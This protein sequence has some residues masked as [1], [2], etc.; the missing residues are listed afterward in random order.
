MLRS[1]DG[2]EVIVPNE[3]LVTTT[4]LNHSHAS[5]D[6]R[7]SAPVRITYGSDVELALRLMEEAARAEPRLVAAPE[8]PTAFVNALGENGIDLELVL[9]VAGP[10][11]G[12]QS[13]R[14][15]GQSTDPGR[16][17]P[18]RGSSSPRRGGTFAWRATGTD[19][20]NEPV[21]ARAAASVESMRRMLQ[22]PPDYRSRALGARARSMEASWPSAD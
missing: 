6:I 15:A 3:T 10:Q 4:V 17:S 12:V 11:A 13:L 9:W 19:M 1:L 18:Q 20:S 22:P 14:S 21:R 5:H 7:V 2:I 8:P 16:R